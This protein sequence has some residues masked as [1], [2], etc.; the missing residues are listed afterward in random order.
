MLHK[1]CSKINPP[2]DDEE[3]DTLL[4]IYVFRVSFLV[5]YAVILLTTFVVLY[6][7]WIGEE[8]WFS[9]VEK[10]IITCLYSTVGN[11]LAHYIFR[12]CYKDLNEVGFCYPMNKDCDLIFSL[13][14]KLDCRKYFV[15]FAI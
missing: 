8:F 11:F 1:S 12:R 9:F 7:N 2:E 3:E 10:C 4:D 14:A 6:I 13:R 15:Y 5:S